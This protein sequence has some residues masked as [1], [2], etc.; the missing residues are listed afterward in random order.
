MWTEFVLAGE[1]NILVDGKAGSEYFWEF[2]N[3]VNSDSVVEAL[4]S[5]VRP[6]SRADMPE[7]TDSLITYLSIYHQLAM[8]TATNKIVP[9]RYKVARRFYEP[10]LLL[11]ALGTIRGGRIKPEIVPE[12]TGTNHTQ[13]R[14][15][16][17]DTI[18]YICAYKKGPDY[19]T[20]AA[21]E[22]T[23]RGVVVWLA[24]NSEIGEN[25]KVFL[26][27]VLAQVRDVVDLDDMEEQQQAAQLAK[28]NLSRMITNFHIPR[29]EVYRK[30]IITDL[31]QPCQEVLIRYCNENC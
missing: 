6:T 2:F 5:E 8:A 15:S 14:R 3:I 1:V 4:R 25:V 16:F 22:K 17:A 9:L 23:P 20:A 29:L 27:D 7:Q 12:T 26:G 10:L 11:H 21:L 24:A 30:K 28:E 31:I 18:A 19:V 13:I